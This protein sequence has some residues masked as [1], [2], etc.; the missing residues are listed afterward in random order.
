MFTVIIPARYASERLPGKPLLEIAGKPMVQH[1]YER[2]LQSAATRVV[3]ATDDTRIAGAVRAFGGEVCMTAA[4]H[5]SGTDR[6]QEASMLL[7]LSDDDLVVN[8]QGDEPLIPTAVIDQVAE[9]IV[10][11]GA[12]MSTLWER[13][14]RWGDVIDPNK[15]K[16]VIRQDGMALYFSR[17][18]IPWDRAL[19]ESTD[20]NVYRRHLGIYAYKVSLLNDYV[21]WPPSPLEETE[22]LE[23]LRVLW[24]GGQ[25]HVAESILA[26][27]AGVDTPSDLARIRTLL[28][29]G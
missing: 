11:S 23:Q 26:I 13:I 10:Q 9:D 27:P 8:V 15:V 1:V 4:S 22:K 3:V 17:A 29:V 14:T 25:I 5:S 12:A 24:H 7:G 20:K 21:G 2:A 28:E 6:L 18:P 19:M 16:V